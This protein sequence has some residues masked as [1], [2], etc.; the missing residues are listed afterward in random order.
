MMRSTLTRFSA[1][2][3]TF[4]CGTTLA[5][6]QTGPIGPGQSTNSPGSTTNTVTA[7]GLSEDAVAS[8]LRSMDPNVKIN[9]GNNN[10]THYSLSVQRGDWNFS[11]QVTLGNRRVLLYCMLGKPVSDPRQ[12]S[13]E[14]LVKLFEIMNKVGPSYFTYDRVQNGAIR[15]CLN[16]KLDRTVSVE[17]LKAGLAEFLQDIQDSYPAWSA[18]GN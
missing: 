10:E 9:R 5:L 1:A 11:I 7:Q 12:L 16:H 4:V 18:L 3:L 2:V 15:L 8:L 13:P 14:A 17:R 6:A